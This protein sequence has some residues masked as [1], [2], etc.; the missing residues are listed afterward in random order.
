MRYTDWLQTW[1][2]RNAS[3]IIKT[4][5]HHIEP[6]LGVFLLMNNY[7]HDVAT[8]LL[9]ASA[10]VLRV[11][12]GHYKTALASGNNN[13]TRA[14]FARI[15]SG[16]RYTARISL[17]WIL[18]GGIPRTLFYRDFEW[19]NAIQH[20]QAGALILKHSMA[21]T[22]VLLGAW[23]WKKTRDE[24]RDI[25]PDASQDPPAPTVVSSKQ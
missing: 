21:F 7:F 14:Y 9:A 8:A 1:T 16:M 22:F 18:V 19:Q 6:T 10:L 3:C 2:C 23:L 17:L 12:A 13:E 20:G 25:L 5:A 15:Y 11:M 4:M 24:F